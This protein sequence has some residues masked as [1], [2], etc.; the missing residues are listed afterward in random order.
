MIQ[1]CVPHYTANKYNCPSL[2][3]CLQGISDPKLRRGTIQLT[4]RGCTLGMQVLIVT[5]NHI[6]T[7]LR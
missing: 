4:F 1:Q 6:L 2:L 3:G 7:H 5:G